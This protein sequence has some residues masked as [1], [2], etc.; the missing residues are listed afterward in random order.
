MHYG[1][2]S[3]AGAA[4]NTLIQDGEN[5]PGD[6]TTYTFFGIPALPQEAQVCAKETILPLVGTFFVTVQDTGMQLVGEEICGDP[7]VT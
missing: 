1:R 3:G 2:L 7:L 5:W 4:C 6:P